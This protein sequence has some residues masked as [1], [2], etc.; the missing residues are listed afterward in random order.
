VAPRKGKGKKG[1]ATKA[2]AP[3][4]QPAKKQAAVE[5]IDEDLDAGAV[6]GR[7]GA[8]ALR[9]AKGAAGTVGVRKGG[10]AKKG[11]K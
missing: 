10:V 9:K 6:R 2:P 5:E 7:K 4:K 1:S 8:K 11:R 3:K